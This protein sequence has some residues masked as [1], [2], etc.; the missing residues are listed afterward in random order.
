MLTPEL[1]RG[2]RQLDAAVL[3]AA[4]L[5]PEQPE[6]V[7]RR[8]HEGTRPAARRG[9]RAIGLVPVA[10]QPHLRDEQ[11][12]ALKEPCSQRVHRRVSGWREYP[13]MPC[14]RIAAMP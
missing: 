7:G 9:V 12:M 5:C 13:R 14:E 8:G 2:S 4:I 11:E 1:L 6:L 10:A 3:E